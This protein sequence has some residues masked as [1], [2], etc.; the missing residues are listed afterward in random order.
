MMSELTVALIRQGAKFESVNSVGSVFAGGSVR[1]PLTLIDK[2][3]FIKQPAIIGM[4]E[5]E[6]D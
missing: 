5:S 6:G 4:S 3:G 2:M 1:I